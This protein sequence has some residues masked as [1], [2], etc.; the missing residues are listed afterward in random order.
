MHISVVIPVFKAKPYL[1]ELVFRLEKA[2]RGLWVDYE[3]IFIEDC[4]EDGTLELASDLALNIP[5]LQIHP[6]EEN[7]GQ[8]PSIL[9]GLKLA[10]GDWV[11]VMDC[12][13][14]EHPEDISRLLKKALEGF[15]IVLAQ[16]KRLASNR[17]KA[18]SSALFYRLMRGFGYI[19]NPEIANFGI[20][21]NEVISEVLK[22]TKPDFFPL[23]IAK[24]T[25][26]KTAIYVD[27][28][29]TKTS[30]YTLAK[31]F[32]LGASIFWQQWR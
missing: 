22:M 27:Y 8:H 1:K 23:R 15:E 30:T 32:K 25:R 10:K 13:L 19:H 12:D 4:S 18:I 7:I 29:E 14:Q 21:S 6:N 9:K 24:S 31:R 26:K 20:Y 5:E 2:L 17:K 3:L 28:T 16:R 11:V